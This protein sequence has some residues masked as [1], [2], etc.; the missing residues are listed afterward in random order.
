MMK[1]S[2]FIRP[3]IVKATAVE[4]KIVL[5]QDTLDNW[6]KTQRGWMYL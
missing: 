5:I 4:G 3:I 1:S 6:L 2:P